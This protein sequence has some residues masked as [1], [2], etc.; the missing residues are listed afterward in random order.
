MTLSMLLLLPYTR[1]L[2]CSLSPSCK[3][4]SS[5]IAN[6]HKLEDGSY[7]HTADGTWVR[8]ALETTYLLEWWR[9]LFWLVR[10]QLK[11]TEMPRSA[12]QSQL[13]S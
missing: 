6:S 4:T 13:S 7:L 9:L 1:P 3:V 10:L 5:L 2:R 8:C 12:L 11:C